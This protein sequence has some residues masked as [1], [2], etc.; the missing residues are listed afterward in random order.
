V[1]RRSIGSLLGIRVILV[2]NI[3]LLSVIGAL[4]FVSYERPVG[5]VLAGLAW[6]VG[7]VLVNLVRFT[8]PYRRER[9]KQRK[10]MSQ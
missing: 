3:V 2:A 8:D 10:P 5:Y 4:F 7:L 6:L 1:P 9:P